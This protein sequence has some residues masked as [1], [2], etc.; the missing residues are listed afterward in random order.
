MRKR[1]RCSW[2]G[3]PLRTDPP[4]AVVREGGRY[5]SAYHAQCK[6]ENDASHRR[7][8][9]P[10]LR[11]LNRVVPAAS[12]PGAADCLPVCPVR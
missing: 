9:A 7:V 8:V 3:K 11:R 10:L 4:Q 6:V 1:E 5:P 2:C 12:G